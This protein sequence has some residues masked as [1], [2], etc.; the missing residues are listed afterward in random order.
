MSKI[1]RL[2]TSFSKVE[3]GQYIHHQPNLKC[4]KLKNLG[5]KF[6]VRLTV[7]SILRLFREGTKTNSSTPLH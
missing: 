5:W 2:K 4:Q 3:K 7:G 1:T 6:C